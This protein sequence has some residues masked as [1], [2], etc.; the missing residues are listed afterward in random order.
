VCAKY[1]SNHSH[2]IHH[3][4]PE[5]VLPTGRSAAKRNSGPRKISAAE[6]IRGRSFCRFKKNVRKG[7]DLFTE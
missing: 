1:E 4:V 7:A 2:G 5:S 6:K 3:S